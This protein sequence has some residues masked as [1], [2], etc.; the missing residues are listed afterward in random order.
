[1]WWRT[2]VPQGRIVR[3]RLDVFLNYWLI[4]RTAAEVPSPDVFPRFKSYVEGRSQGIQ[5]IAGDV[6]RVGVIYR[7]FEDVDEWS[8][9]GTFFYRWHAMD[10]GVITPVLLWLFSQP[11]SVLDGA[12][13]QRCLQAL[14]SFLVRRMLCRMT[15]KNYN[16]LF[17]D[18]LSRLDKGTHE[19]A[20]DV[21]VGYLTE[22]EADS[23]LWPDDRMFE[24]ALLDLPLYRLL[25]RRRLRMVLESLEDALRGPLAEEAN[26]GRGK[27]TIE[28]VLPQ[29]WREY[30]PLDAD[31]GFDE[32][33]ERERLL[34]SLGNLTLVNVRLNPALSN[35]PWASK[36][37]GLA[38]HSV[39]Y[40]NK[41]LLTAYADRDWDE[42]AI[43]ER[44]S[45]LAAAAK[46][47]WPSAERLGASSKASSSS[48]EAELA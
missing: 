13:R 41:E 16:E 10:A 48:G 17:L 2:E 7:A 11:V 18:L 31:S 39:L 4:M 28:H 47:V 26:V 37:N 40:L 3:P 5:D 24:I 42:A 27:L 32:E 45:T 25:T 36:Q 46:L 23:R 8:L 9:E 33:V 30:W 20:D 44:G 43:R 22:Q 14:E 12:R 29:S 35:G 34:H 38:E 15:T 1:V 19:V 21:L 6:S